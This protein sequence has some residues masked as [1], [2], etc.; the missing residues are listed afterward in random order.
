MLGN[1]GNFAS[2]DS[3]TINSGYT[4]NANGYIQFPFVGSVKVAGL[5]EL[6]AR[7]EL[8]QRLQR[9]YIDPQ[10]VLKV[11]QYRGKHVYV[12]GSVKTPGQV[13]ISDIPMTLPEALSRVGGPDNE[14]DTSH[15]VLTRDKKAYEINLPQLISHAINPATILLKENDILRVTPR[16]ETMVSV[17][18]EVNSPGRRVTHNGALSLTEALSESGGINAVASNAGQIYV[19]RQVNTSEATVY[20]I[21]V[22]AA[23]NLALA[24]Q[25]ELKAR[26]IVFVNSASIAQWNRVITLLFGSVSAVETTNNT[27]HNR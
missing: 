18:G 4:V 13:T 20:H 8:T 15:L 7:D 1:T 3:Q 11:Q 14:A 5:T 22:R 17:I 10:V 21:A 9:F 26:D 23:E 12:A 6:Q 19:I 16:E 27:L 25:F 24:D 2:A